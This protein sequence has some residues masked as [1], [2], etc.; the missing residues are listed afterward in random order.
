LV[1]TS[2]AISFTYMMQKYI[3]SANQSADQ[4][5]DHPTDQSADKLADQSADQLAEF[6]SRT[7]LFI[8]LGSVNCSAYITKFSKN[9][10]AVQRYRVLSGMGGE[11]IDQQLY[12]LFNKKLI[13]NGIVLNQRGIMRL[14]R[15]VV[16]TK[17]NLSMNSNSNVVVECLYD[18][19]DHVLQ[20]NRTEFESLIQPLYDQLTAML[21][22]L[23]MLEHEPIH[24]IELVG[25]ISRIP[26]TSLVLK[27]FSESKLNNVP[28]CKS[29][30]SDESVAIGCTYMTAL[31]SPACS[32]KNMKVIESSVTNITFMT[33][34]TNTTKPIKLKTL[35]ALDQ[36]LGSQTIR[37]KPNNRTEITIYT[38]N[39]PNTIGSNTIGQNTVEEIITRQIEFPNEKGESTLRVYFDS[40][41][42][43]RLV[44][45]TNAL[46]VLDPNS[47]FVG[48]NE[49]KMKKMIE[50]ERQMELLENQTIAIENARNEIEAKIYNI[51]HHKDDL[52]TYLTKNEYEM[53]RELIGFDCMEIDDLEILNQTIKT[54]DQMFGWANE[55]KNNQNSQPSE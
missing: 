34:P 8:D 54:I 25:G 35:F 30:N 20:M 50:D 39:M 12:D 46:F 3:T 27:Q 48:N 24:S 32:F 29:L 55:R 15:G 10:F 38:D 40:M 21:N 16:R 28:I 49:E 47:L 17:Y 2:T 18:G 6:K 42:I 26:L 44:I 53:L 43:L 9:E 31:L 33:R 22:N 41:G 14:R 11:W 45:G 1:N 19:V 4:S 7:V 5:A 23:I 36:K 37:L 51:S 13:E 52:Q